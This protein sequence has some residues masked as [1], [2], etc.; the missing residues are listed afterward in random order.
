MKDVLVDRL[1][2]LDLSANALGEFDGDSDE[3]DGELSVGTCNT[4]TTGY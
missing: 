2:H 1:T 3:E 4:L